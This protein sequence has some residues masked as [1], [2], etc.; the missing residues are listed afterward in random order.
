M[1]EKAKVNF[2]L[3]LEERILVPMTQGCK[4]EDCPSY[5][6]RL[7]IKTMDY[8]WIIDGLST[9]EER[10]KRLESASFHTYCLGHRKTFHGFSFV[11]SNLFCTF[12]KAII[13]SN[14]FK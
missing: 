9:E 6:H 11:I 1:R 5:L 12:A 7:S 14:K 10:S 4:S 2:L 8:R 3:S 13:K